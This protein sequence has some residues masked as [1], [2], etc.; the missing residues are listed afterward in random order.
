M[1]IY[2]V[3]VSK[4]W[5][6]EFFSAKNL[7]RVLQLLKSADVMDENH[8]F[9][10]FCPTLNVSDYKIALEADGYKNVTPFVWAKDEVPHCSQN[11]G[12]TSLEQTFL[13]AFKGNQTWN[14]DITETGED[15]HMSVSL[16][17]FTYT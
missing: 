16:A 2:K 3:F 4:S 11:R 8:T 6:T 1:F 7:S 5:D 13:V 17:L 9:V 12:C 15:W 10:G 14:F